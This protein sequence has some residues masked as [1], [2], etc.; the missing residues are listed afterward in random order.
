MQA[1]LGA[2]F[3]F[4]SLCF[5]SVGLVFAFGF[6]DSSRP[7]PA[8]VSLLLFFSTLWEPVEK[9]LTFLMTIHSRKCEYEADEYR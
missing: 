1:Y 3:F 9:T 6:D 2:A 4:F 7:V 5:G 8:I